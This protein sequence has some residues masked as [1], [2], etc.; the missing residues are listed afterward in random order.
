MKMRTPNMFK[1]IRII[2]RSIKM[3]TGSVRPSQWWK[4]GL[5]EKGFRP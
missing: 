4:A 5:K 1:S 3:V 2:T